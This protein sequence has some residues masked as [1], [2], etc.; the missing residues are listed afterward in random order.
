MKTFPLKVGTTQKV[1]LIVNTVIDIQASEIEIKK[2]DTRNR[3][4]EKQSFFTNAIYTDIENP[5]KPI[6]N[7]LELRVWWGSWPKINTQK[8]IA[9]IYTSAQR[10]NGL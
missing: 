5:P 3:K 7:L 6:D 4:E 1:P 10:V 9:F 2:W 8:S